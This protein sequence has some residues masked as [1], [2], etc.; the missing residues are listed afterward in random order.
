MEKVHHQCNH[1]R[2]LFS[3][4]SSKQP[5]RL[6]LPACSS[7]FPSAIVH[8]GQFWFWHI[9]P[10]FDRLIG[11]SSFTEWVH[12]CEVWYDRSWLKRVHTFRRM[13]RSNPIQALYIWPSSFL[14]VDSFY[15]HIWP[16]FDLLR[17]IGSFLWEKNL[18]LL[19]LICVV[20]PSGRMWKTRS[21][22]RM[23]VI[24]VISEPG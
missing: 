10:L 22:I 4:P 24:S 6:V 1:L 5:T 21:N 12:F 16:L 2:P 15:R 7:S 9:W 11:F 20:D 18:F 13:W 17:I 3:T 23:H 8:S 19:G 14:E